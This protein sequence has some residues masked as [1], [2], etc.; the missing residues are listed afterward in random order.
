MSDQHRTKPTE[1]CR[2]R[3]EAK[4]NRSEAQ[5]KREK[6]FVNYLAITYLAGIA[7]AYE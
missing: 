5:K 7:F 4:V 3:R 6:Y 1:Y 2:Q